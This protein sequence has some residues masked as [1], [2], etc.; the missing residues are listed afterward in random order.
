ML[1]HCAGQPSQAELVANRGREV[2]DQLIDVH[3]AAPQ[4]VPSELV[5]TNRGGAAVND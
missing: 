4:A 5:A 3:P 1:Q 2:K